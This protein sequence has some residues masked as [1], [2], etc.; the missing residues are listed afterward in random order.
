MEHATAGVVRLPCHLVRVEHRHTRDTV[1]RRHGLRVV[2]SAA[3]SDPGGVTNSRPSLYPETA[4]VDTLRFRHRVDSANYGRMGAHSHRDGPRQERWVQVEGVRVGAYP[5]GLVYTE[6]RGA[7]MLDGP[8]A[9]HL[10]SAAEVVDA[11]RRSG[12]ILQSLGLDSERDPRV[13]RIDLTADLM[14]DDGDEGR[15]LLRAA[16]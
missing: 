7:V 6:A 8:E 12:E 2:E 4:G 15:A 16:S 9:H 3:R 13:A 5:D 14:F 1:E 11:G 10:L